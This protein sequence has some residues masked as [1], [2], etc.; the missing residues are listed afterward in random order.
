MV[1]NVYFSLHDP[2]TKDAMIASC[3]K[4]LSK[5]DGEAFF[6]AGTT[7]EHRML[8]SNDREFDVAVVIVF[9]SKDDLVKFDASERHKAF[10]A[11]NRTNWK[12]IRV[13]DALADE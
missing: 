9:R 13:F 5:H 12:K 4:Y 2:S 7:A 6:A 3:K 1:H 8:K 10:V 11:E